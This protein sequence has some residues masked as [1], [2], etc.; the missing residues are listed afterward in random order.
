MRHLK[1]LSTWQPATRNDQAVETHVELNTKKTRIL[2][3]S[4][5]PYDDNRYFLPLAKLFAIA[6]HVGNTK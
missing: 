1:N 4:Y 2:I 6:K 5:H 3:S